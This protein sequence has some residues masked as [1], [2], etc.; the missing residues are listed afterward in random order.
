[1]NSP[2]RICL[3]RRRVARWL[4]SVRLCS[5]RASACQLSAAA[6][7]QAPAI[8]S[9]KAPEPTKALEPTKAPEAT[10]APAAAAPTTTPTPAP[11]LPPVVPGKNELVYGLTLVVSGIDPHIHS[12]SELGIPLNSVYDTL[13]YLST[14]YKFVPGLAESWTISD[15]LKTYTF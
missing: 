13:V 12:S 10:K 11:T 1:M 2:I 15:D 14:D 9:T 3:G 7:T 5:A 8:A 4:R 6:A